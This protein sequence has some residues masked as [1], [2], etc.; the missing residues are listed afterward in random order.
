MLV[1]CENMQ[2][3]EG[4]LSETL[5]TKQI[6]EAKI[7][8]TI[9]DVFSHNTALQHAPKDSDTVHSTTQHQAV[10]ALERT[11]LKHKKVVMEA[12]LVCQTDKLKNIA[13][14]QV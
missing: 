11:P 3:F 14:K 10:I 7:E 4:T 2:D 13:V 12:T 6:S 9:V 8:A 5:K 1:V